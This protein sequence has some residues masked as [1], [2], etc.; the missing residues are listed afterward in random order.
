MSAAIRFA[1]LLVAATIGLAHAQSLERQLDALITRDGL[2]QA[3][4]SVAFVP[5]LVRTAVLAADFPT[6]SSTPDFSYNYDWETGAL[7]RSAK[8]PGSI[9]LDRPETLGRGRFEIGAS[10]FYSSADKQDGRSLEGLVSRFRLQ[11][12]AGPLPIE[13]RFTDF[14]LATAGVSFSGSYGITERWDVNLLVPV[15]VTSLEVKGGRDSVIRGT[16]VQIGRFAIDEE[17]I[18]IGDVLVRTKLQLVEAAGIGLAAGF[19]LRSPTGKRADFQGL[20]D[21]TLAPALVA[22][23]DFGA[24]NLH[25]TLG[26]EAN[27]GELARSRVRYGIGA[28]VE[29]LTGCALLVDVL[30]SSGVVSETFEAG[31]LR[32][33]SF[34]NLPTVQTVHRRFV[35]L[36]FTA[37]RTDVVDL[38][39][40]GKV[41]IREN[42]SGFLSVIVPLTHDGLR[43]DVVPIGGLQVT[44]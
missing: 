41:R 9:F 32:L 34:E 10:S 42:V 3:D 36:T 1:A 5:R 35:P 28:S 4:P 6:T 16:P 20:G 26:M 18:G 30:G 2:Q 44:F 24:H 25:A 7:E 12:A 14:T 29:V 22:A 38:A 15:D 23:R 11:T 8:A 17:R 33:V 21:W 19:T 13:L 37:A 43:P 31:R 39:V 27:A 40:G